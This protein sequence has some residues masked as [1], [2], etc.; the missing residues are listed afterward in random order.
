M[1]GEFAVQKERFRSDGML[2]ENGFKKNMR[3]QS[4]F[5]MLEV[6]ITIVVVAIGLLGVAG[7][8]VS[9]IKLTE[10][11]EVRSNATIFAND[12]IDRIRANQ[13]QALSY[14]IGYGG[15]PASVA[16]LADRD[17]REW[18][19]SLANAT[20]GLPGGDGE[21]DVSEDVAD[22][23]VVAGA[24]LRCFRVQVTLRWNEG[25]QRGES[26]VV[27]KQFLRIVTRV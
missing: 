11:A 25:R 19:L 24:P 23:P 13:A 3:A 27:P 18:K 1:A 20:R 5:S 10:L 4:G 26:A 16:T 12:I 8:Q 17:L 14:D 15:P 6:L 21:I 9:S 22:C 7:M 2:V